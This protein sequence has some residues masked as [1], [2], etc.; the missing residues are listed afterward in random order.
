LRMT[1]KSARPSDSCSGLWTSRASRIAPLRI[2]TESLVE[3]FLDQKL[4]LRRAL[5]TGQDDRVHTL[6]I[7]GRPHKDVVDT[8]PCE[9]RCVRL[10]ITLDSKDS[11]LHD[12]RFPKLQSFEVGAYHPRV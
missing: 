9:G 2:F 10:K 1:A 6:E 3:T 12:L 7:A 11:D 8:H 5:A 4:P